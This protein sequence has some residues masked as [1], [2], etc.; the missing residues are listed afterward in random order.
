VKNSGNVWAFLLVVVV[1]AVSLSINARAQLSE[2]DVHDFSDTGDGSEPTTGLIFDKSGNLYGTTSGTA[3]EL[4][5]VSGGGSNFQ[6]IYGFTSSSEAFVPSSALT[7]DTEGNLYGVSYYGG[8]NNLG[9]VYELALAGGIWT[10]TVLHS[11]GSGGDGANPQGNL[12]FD[13]HGNLYGTTTARTVFELSPSAGS[14]NIKVL[15]TF[16]GSDGSNPGSNLLIDST[17]NLYGS[18]RT[19]G[20][21]D[22]AL[23]NGCGTVFR[24]RHF[25]NSWSF[26]VLYAFAGTKGSGPQSLVMDGTGNIYGAAQSGGNT[27]CSQGC[28]VVFKLTPN[29]KGTWKQTVLHSFI[30]QGPNGMNPASLTFD[31]LGNLYGVTNATNLKNT[32]GTV[33]EI[34]PA[35]GGGW[36]FTRLFAFDKTHGWA[37]NG[38]I[39]DTQGN[40][41]GT[42]G[43]GGAHGFGVLFE[44]SP[45]GDAK[46]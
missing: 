5:P 14:W 16:A 25:G 28:G 30:G 46:K 44:L 10:Q 3:F 4:S 18:A 36:T 22:C 20:S 8:T 39:P 32:G 7:M 21:G 13:V 45:P 23:G 24:L 19:G 2:T 41:F 15:H 43:E 38:I 11:F 33:F 27:Q 40:L 26:N 34:S 31:S 37:P 12:V 1:V 9:T 17:G 29:A 35:T 6:T 42:T